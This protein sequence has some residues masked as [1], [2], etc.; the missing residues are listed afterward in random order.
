LELSFGVL[1]S[2]MRG[3]CHV[4]TLFIWSDRGT[5]VASSFFGGR[6]KG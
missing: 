1:L 4:V 3:R 5:R 6:I 2:A